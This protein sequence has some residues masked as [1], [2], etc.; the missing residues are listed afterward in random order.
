MK[1]IKH[2]VS[3]KD[4][5]IKAVLVK[6]FRAIP[7]CDNYL[8]IEGSDSCYT[9]ESLSQHIDFGKLPPKKIQEQINNAIVPIL[10]RWEFRDIPARWYGCKTQLNDCIQNQKTIQDNLMKAYGRVK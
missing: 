2:V 6:K 4:I 7:L 9:V 10:A 5:E 1:C 8:Q 3:V